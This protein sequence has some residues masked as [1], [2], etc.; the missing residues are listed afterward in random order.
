MGFRPLFTVSVNHA[1]FSDGAWRGL[2]FVAN[3]ETQKVIKGANVLLRQTGSGVCVFYDEEKSEALRLCAEDS[4]GVLRF[5]F[6]VYA[7]DR[8][9]AN[10]TAPVMP[11]DGE[12][13]YFD[14]GV[15]VSDTATGEVRLNR[16][17]FVS[18]KD[19]AKID[20][21]M[22]DGVLGANDGRMPPDFV[23]SINVEF[24]RIGRTDAQAY[25][26]KFNT[27]QSFWKYHLLG[28]MNKSAPFIIDLDNQFEF[29]FCGE[30]TLPG[31]RPARIFRS[32][33]LIPVLEKSNYRF[34]LREQGPGSGAGKILI[35]R[36]PVASEGGLGMELINGKR[37]I[38][39]ES[40]INF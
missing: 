12:I 35:K 18:E 34:Q 4:N 26:I 40:Y 21:L 31:N 5:S 39:S 17:D 20:A 36:L 29:E 19:I 23:V 16:D 13:F 6:K 24:K 10:Y 32:K 1:Y 7:I 38:V 37:E 28:S 25:D 27:R 14:S 15:A 8:T 3:L 30:A 22:A 33:A 9:F 11:K 2:N